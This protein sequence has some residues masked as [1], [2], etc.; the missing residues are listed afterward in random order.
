VI[1]RSRDHDPLRVAV[2]IALVLLGGC[3][4]VTPTSPASLLPSP[5]PEPGVL[6]RDW[7]QAAL[8][9]QPPGDPLATVP[10]YEGPGSLGHPGHYQG[11]MAS[12][13]DVAQ[14]GPGFV[15]VGYILEAM[16][17]RATAWASPDG[18]AWTLN[19]DFPGGEASVAWSVATDGPIAVAVGVVKGAPATWYS[20]DG[21]RWSRSEP[22]RD[23]PDHGELRAVIAT[24]D[25][26]VA[27]GSDERD[28]LAPRAIF[29]TS[30]D[31]RT[32]ERV[33]D[34]PA[35]ADARVE[36]LARLGGS[37]VAAG[38]AFTGA[39]PIGAASWS[40]ADGGPWERASDKDLDGGQMHAV[41]AN[42][43]GLVG[44][45]TD[46]A[47]H[48]AM[49]W[50]SRDGLAWTVAPDAASLDNYGLQI[51]MRDVVRLED[52]DIAVGHLVFGTQYPTGLIWQST[53]GVTW[54]RAPNAPVLEQVKFAGVIGGPDWAIAVGD[55]GGPDAVVPTILVSPWPP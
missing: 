16:G 23:A 43:K 28:R 37:V 39:D 53:D 41:S 18:G 1:R 35:F 3:S 40:W 17:P 9:E 6:G 52:R 20:G 44:V 38:T 55:W 54:E 25:G 30:A 46:V 4:V 13:R 12:V 19:A 31:G 11:G 45:G 36:G 15:A 22:A 2:L 10:P 14:G 32:W 47:G 34:A 5:P 42:A 8:V 21:V 27:A 24:P 29:W 50:S 7:G 26:F 49:V 33:A 51:E 48:R